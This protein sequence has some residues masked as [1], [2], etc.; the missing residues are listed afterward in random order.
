MGGEIF[1]NAPPTRRDPR[2]RDGG[3][4]DDEDVIEMNAVHRGASDW[5]QRAAV[6]FKAV[7]DE[8]GHPTGHLAISG[9]IRPC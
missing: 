9:G 8:P 4:K 2:A 5:V 1:R 3:M 6:R 7:I